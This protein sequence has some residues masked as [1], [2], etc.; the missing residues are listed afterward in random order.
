MDSL[1]SV[2]FDNIS[3][4]DPAK[5][6]KGL[7]QIEGLLAQICLSRTSTPAPTSISPPPPTKPTRTPSTPSTAAPKPLSALPS[8]PAYLEFFRLQES[9]EWNGT[10][11]P[12]PPPRLP[13]TNP[14]LLQ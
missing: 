10:P 2:S 9:F 4:K 14:P 8:D 11:S 5:I 7:R 3:S 6:R 12:S 13:L 1:L